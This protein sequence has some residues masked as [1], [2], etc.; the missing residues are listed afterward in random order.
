MFVKELYKDG[1]SFTGSAAFSTE[2][3]VVDADE[4]EEDVDGGGGCCILAC[5]FERGLCMTSVV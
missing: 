1:F 3:E 5:P 2:E 4:D